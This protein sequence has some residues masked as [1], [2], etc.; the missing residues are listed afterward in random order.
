MINTEHEWNTNVT[1]ASF[2]VRIQSFPEMQ[3]RIT[4]TSTRITNIRVDIRNNYL[5]KANRDL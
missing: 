1:M 4:K 2:K 3:R 5:S